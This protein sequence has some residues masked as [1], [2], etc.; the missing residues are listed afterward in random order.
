MENGGN[1]LGQMSSRQLLDLRQ[2]L[3]KA[4]RDMQV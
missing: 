3:E 2:T 1:D 4:D